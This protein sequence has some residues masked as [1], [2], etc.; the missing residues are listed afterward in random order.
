[1]A[2]PPGG[3]TVIP[4]RVELRSKEDLRDWMEFRELSVRKLAEKAGISHSTVGHLH[5]GH[6]ARC[7]P[8][9]AARIEKALNCLPGTLFRV[10][11]SRVARDPRQF[12][13]RAAS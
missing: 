7:R 11:E 12:R 1:M 13:G 8:D 5:S 2:R 3:G 10:I 9:T 4:L 6:Y